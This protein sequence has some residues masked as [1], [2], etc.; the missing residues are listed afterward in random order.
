MVLEDD[1]DQ[2]E[3]NDGGMVDEE[4]SG[5]CAFGAANTDSSL[6]SRTDSYASSLGR[7]LGGVQRAL[8]AVG[9]AVAPG[10][11]AESGAGWL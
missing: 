4:G 9:G 3:G 11:S 10:W 1:K 5:D 8:K 6:G 7:K 2:E